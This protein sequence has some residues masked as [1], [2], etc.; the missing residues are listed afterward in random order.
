MNAPRP[1]LLALGLA[2][3]AATSGCN[4]NANDAPLAVSVIGSAPRIVDA[5]QVQPRPAD[6][7]VMDAVRQGLVRYDAAGQIEPG[8]AIRWAIS[9]DGLYYT[10]R[11]ERSEA[12]LVA[13]KLRAMIARGSRNPLKPVLGG[14]DEIV[15]VT[16]EVVEIRLRGARPNLLDL[17]AQ[18][19]MGL[20]LGKERS[21]PFVLMSAADAVPLQLVP[22]PLAEEDDEAERDEDAERR[23]SVLLRG[24]R[25][26]L[27]VARFASGEA[28]VV[29]NGRYDSLPLVR[30]AGLRPR[31]L[32]VD[33]VDGL[34]GLKIVSRNPLLS[35]VE[36]RR[37]VAM[38]IDR[39]RI[40]TSFGVAEWHAIDRILP[41]GM[42]ELPQPVRPGWTD[43]KLED[44]RQ[45]A[46]AAIRQ[47]IANNPGKPLTLKVALPEGAG[48]RLLFALLRAD[49]AQIGITAVRVDAG[50]SA[51]LE[52]VDAVAPGRAATWYLRH[53]ECARSIV[54]SERADQA[55]EIARNTPSLIERAAQIADADLKLAEIVPFIPIARPLRWS[56]A[57]PRA[58]GFRTN[59]RGVHPLNHLLED[60]R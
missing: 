33:P 48:S 28:D 51:D 23:R 9:D 57:S 1:R 54:C 43:L 42:H 6:L 56:L 37:A 8:L 36:N 46:R 3:I 21:L 18:P 40:L 16:P 10:F 60:P 13:R 59:E 47:W 19:E 5:N 20:D 12:G 53:F 38:A 32:R 52:L 55:L 35:A 4:R 41:D 2:L 29:L 22:P 39:D 26:A 50:D 17:L 34:F 27:A 45:T 30:A 49:W 7:V 25:G 24:E 11:L 15:A 58:T 14:I 31:V 44:R